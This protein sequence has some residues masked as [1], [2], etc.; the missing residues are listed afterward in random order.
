MAAPCIPGAHHGFPHN[1]ALAAEPHHRPLLAGSGC[2]ETCS[3]ECACREP[4]GGTGQ[5]VRALPSG[6]P[7]TFFSVQHFKGRKNRCYRLAVRAVIR[8]FVKCTQARRLKKRNLRTVSDAPGSPP[9]PP[10]SLSSIFPRARLSSLP[11]FGSSAF[12]PLGVLLTSLDR[13]CVKGERLGIGTR[14]PLNQVLS[15]KEI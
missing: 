15:T 12:P 6:H 4:M 9:R 10:Q 8:A 7:P 11:G 13:S 3:G 2:A 5:V 14:Q 1:A